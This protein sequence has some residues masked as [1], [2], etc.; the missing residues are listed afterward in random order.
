MH[1]LIGLAMVRNESDIVESF[2][3]HN[4]LFLDEL[5]V[6]LQPCTDATLAILNALVAEGLPLTIRADGGS[7]FRQGEIL[8]RYSKDLLRK[9]G[10]NVVIVLD[11]DEFIKAPSKAKLLE[12]LAA[13]PDDWLACWRWQ[14]YVPTV[15]VE[16]TH[17]PVLRS[18]THR[19]RD[20]RQTTK[21]ILT[22]VFARRDE[23]ALS[24]G[25][26]RAFSTIPNETV[27]VA[28]LKNLALAHFPVR[29][30]DQ[31]MRK[32]S[33]GVQM[34]NK[35]FSGTDV[36]MHW[37]LIKDLIDSNTLSFRLLQQIA[38]DYKFA[39]RIIEQDVLSELVADPI[40]CDFSLRYR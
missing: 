30:R 19:L 2:V 29:S 3:R 40:P 23:L 38:A 11:A 8:T 37:R 10:D 34:L 17:E 22:G 21:M 25:S 9:Q 12:V 1:K 5:H 27:K 13:V 15:D 7:H 20:E 33:S 39:D 26:H 4:V 36:G 31:I 6:V 14:S 18:I 24:D 35:D 16:L 28:N 32:V